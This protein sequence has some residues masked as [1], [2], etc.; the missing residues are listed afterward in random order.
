MDGGREPEAPPPADAPAFVPSP[1]GETMDIS[2]WQLPKPIAAMRLSN[3][4]SAFLLALVAVLKIDSGS[5]DISTGVVALYTLSFALVIFVFETHLS[6]TAKVIASNLGFMFFITQKRASFWGGFFSNARARL[7]LFRPPPRERATTRE[8]HGAG[9]LAR[10]RIISDTPLVS[11]AAPGGP[12]F[13]SSAPRIFQKHTQRYRASGRMCFMVLVAMLCF[14]GNHA[15]GIFTGLFVL[16]TAVFNGVILCTYP[17]YEK[18][19]R[20]VDLAE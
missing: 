18:S 12:R 7:T 10:P 4:I 20:I 19:C 13:R 3:V 1:S 11:R 5:A 17:L 6:C 8:T 9:A 16:C 14:S 15:L 2:C